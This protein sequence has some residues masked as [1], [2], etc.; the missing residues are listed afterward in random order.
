MPKVWVK[1]V[2]NQRIIHSITG[3][4]IVTN[5]IWLSYKKTITWL[6]TRFI[7]LTSLYFSPTLS[8][9]KNLLN[10]LLNKSFTLNPQH[11][12]LEPLNEI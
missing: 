10:N 4:Y 11:L 5:V 9:Y 6:Q 1:N 8:T 12:L 3:V 2:N 7:N